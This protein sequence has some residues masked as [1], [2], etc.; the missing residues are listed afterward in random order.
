VR[1]LLAA[2]SPRSASGVRNRAL[3]AVL[4]RGGLRLA[5][6][7]ALRVAD[8]DLEAG[9]VRVLRGKGAR[10]RTVGLDPG[11]CALVERWTERR[12]QLGI[13]RRSP[14][15]CTI[16]AGERRGSVLRPGEALDP[17]YVRAALGRLAERAGVDKRVHPHGLRHTHAAELAA[18]GVPSTVI[19]DQLGHS[20]L[21]TTDRYL[22]HVAP[23]EVL[24][25][26]SRTEG[27]GSGRSLRIGQRGDVPRQGGRRGD[28]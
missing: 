10:A 20:N 27:R 7:L 1:A 2:A 19:R 12:R 13:G 11:A 22:R 5:E 21:S 14:L 9:A 6:A 15:F 26:M 16:S 17:R 8:V 24:R 25:T 4:Y 23:Q 18:E 3:V 28:L